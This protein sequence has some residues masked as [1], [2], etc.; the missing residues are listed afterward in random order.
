MYFKIKKIKQEL[1]KIMTTEIV[2]KL[3]F[4]FIKYTIFNNYL[5]NNMQK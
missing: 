1:F 4:L 3:F 5:K 2:K